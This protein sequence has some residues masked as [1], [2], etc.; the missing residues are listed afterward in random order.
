MART[1][2]WVALAVVLGLPHNGRAQE[3]ICGYPSSV[4]AFELSSTFSI[5]G[6]E[7]MQL[8]SVGVGS[9]ADNAPNSLDLADQRCIDGAC[10]VYLKGDNLRGLISRAD[11][12]V[13][14][15]RCFFGTRLECVSVLSLSAD[16]EELVCNSLVLPESYTITP[17]GVL[18]LEPGGLGGG[19]LYLPTELEINFF[20][21]SQPPVLTE[22]EP[23]FSDILSW[24]QTFTAS[25][26][27][28]S[29][30]EGATRASHEAATVGVRL[31]CA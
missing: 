11:A 5:D 1:P 15:L 26:R 19:T 31:A 21:S 9:Q 8:S 28:D 22:L 7:P 6:F 2:W 10:P 4:H 30:E 18:V 29:P 20:D 12:V 23:P 13:S 24:P 3:Q 14:D 27:R 17:F 16:G 25:P